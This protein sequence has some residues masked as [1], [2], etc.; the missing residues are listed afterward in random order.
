MMNYYYVFYF[1][2]SHVMYSGMMYY[3]YYYAFSLD[4]YVFVLND[5]RGFGSKGSC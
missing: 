3:Y 4:I 5:V 2:L 1:R